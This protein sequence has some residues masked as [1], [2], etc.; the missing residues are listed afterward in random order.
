MVVA[1]RILKAL[2]VSLLLA[3]SA[4]GVSKLN[5]FGMEAAS[6][7]VADQVYQR[8]TAADYG[9]DRKGQAAISVVYLDEASIETMKGYGWTRF[10]PT[11]DQQWLM[12]EDLMLVGGGPPAVMF[13]DFVYMG[14]GGPSEGF[15]VFLAGVSAATK[16][17]AW[18]NKPG[19]VADPLVKIGCIVLSGGVPMIFAKPS[20]GELELFTDVQRQ[21]DSVAVLAPALVS[22][23]AYPTIA[24]YAFDPA[25]AQRLGVHGFDVS[26]AVAAYAAWC[27]KRADACRVEPFQRM[28]RQAKAALDGA[29]PRTI[30]PDA[31][32]DAPLDVVWGSRPDP[33]YV[34]MTRRVSGAA[35][36]CRTAGSGWRERLVEQWAGLRGPGAGKAQECPYNLAVGYDRLVSGVGLESADL[37]RLLANKIVMV[38]G[39]FR[40]SNDWV[41]SPVHGQLPGVH[42]HAMALDNLMQYGLDYRRNAAALIDSDFLKSGLIALLAFFGV[43]GVMARN[44]LLDDAIERGM[45]PRLRVAV[46]GPLYLFLF[47]T[48]FA[49]VI[50]ATWFAVA[51][52]NRSPINWI[53]LT[54]VAFGFLFYATRQTLPAD[55]CGTLER[56]PVV[57][58]ILAAHRL[59]TSAMKFEE[60]RLPIKPKPRPAPTAPTNPA[61]ATATAPALE[62]AA[63]V[64]A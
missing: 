28:R 32:F 16:A 9:K 45:E 12:L 62:P 29:P 8:I 38:G 53:G 35:P 25:K 56:L 60:D 64:E 63:H 39:H 22:A 54:S 46:Y 3:V 51:F 11:F 14:Q 34:D 57:R 42:L 31:A 44:S 17:E 41:D 36:P 20:P 10:P 21:L 19:C 23:E 1:V 2:L 5:L 27:L 33:A 50:G 37:E 47:A 40:A 6:D 26:P 49:V 18:M 13:V 59:C 48:S 43:L 30:N 7:R 55:I 58:R 15:D 24:D 52:A 4:Y 61:A